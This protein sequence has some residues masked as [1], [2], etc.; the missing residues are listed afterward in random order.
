M[1]I[2]ALIESLK[3]QNLPEGEYA[4]FGS[5]VMAVR[6][7]R[8]APNIDIIVTDKLWN[9]LSDRGHKPDEE[10]FIRISQI[11]I[12]NWWFAPTRK[13]IPTMIKEAEIIKD[14]PFVR[15]EEVR[16]YKTFINREKDKNDVKL[17]NQFLSSTEADEPTALG[18]NT[19]KKLLDIFKT[20]VDKRLGSQILSLVVFGSVSRGEAKGSSDIDMF[21]FFDDSK[22][23]RTEL[24]E[25]LISII[26]YLRET[27]EYRKL[28][29][30]KIYPEIYPFLIS[31]S[32]ASDYLW[33]FF[34]ATEQGIIFKDTGNFVKKLIGEIKNKIGNL[35]GRRVKLPNGKTCWILFDN[36]S[37]ILSSPI[38][39]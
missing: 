18:I 30:N 19:Y 10:G 20:E 8:E 31:K 39:L 1:K 4:V 27:E 5:A 22:I 28:T 21:V 25:I 9:E 37:K 16:H 38:N 33:V 29:D 13:N 34:D 15:L 2:E 36:F 7:F 35:G 24:N 11:K 32:K 14:V 17:I 23:K 12:S 6:G 3:K 26:L